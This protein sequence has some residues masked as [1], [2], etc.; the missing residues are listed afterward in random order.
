MREALESYGFFVLAILLALVGLSASLARARRIPEPRKPR[1][2]LNYILLWPLLFDRVRARDP[3]R[4]S[5]LFTSREL[6][7]WGV[8]LALIIVGLLFF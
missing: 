4:G 1:S 2:L 6:L 7:G 3:Q 8:V 5:R